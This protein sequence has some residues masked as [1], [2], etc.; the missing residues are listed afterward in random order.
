MPPLGEM[1]VVMLHRGPPHYGNS[2]HLLVILVF[3]S[4]L[5]FP[6]AFSGQCSLF[7]LVRGCLLKEPGNLWWIENKGMTIIFGKNKFCAMY[8][9]NHRQLFKKAVDGEFSGIT[10]R[11]MF[12]RKNP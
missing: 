9:K 8:R 3:A 6:K 4:F 2:S 12:S 1:V 11:A 5:L 7:V 10:N